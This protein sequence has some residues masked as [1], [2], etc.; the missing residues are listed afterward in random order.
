MSAGEMMTMKIKRS[1]FSCMREGLMIRGTEFRP[2]TGERLPIAIVSHEFMC[3]RLFSARYALMLAKLGF[4]AFCFDFCGGCI[5]G[6]SGGR[7]TDMSVMTEMKDLKAVIDYAES[8]PYTD[9]DRL[10]LMGCSQGGLVSALTAAELGDAVERLILFYPALSIPDDAR[11]GQMI[12]ARI[13]PGNV[14]ETFN[15][16]VMRLGRRYAE[17]VMELD[18]FSAISRYRGRVLIVHGNADKLVDISYSR[19]AQEVYENAILQEIDGAGH[20]F[21][22]PAHV[23]EA[24]DTVRAFMR[25]KFSDKKQ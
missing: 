19:R 25:G 10:V 15:C 8:L 1:E 18:P 3:N 20:I 12:K 6:A 17:D 16:G 24:V 14:P 13:D 11:K 23:R 21:I 7:T 4:A 9:A 5:V 22:A 2:D